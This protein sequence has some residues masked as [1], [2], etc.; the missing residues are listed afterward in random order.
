MSA[1]NNDSAKGLAESSLQASTRAVLRPSVVGDFQWSHA[2]IGQEPCTADAAQVCTFL[3]Q[4][5][6]IMA[7]KVEL[8]LTPAAGGRLSW[9]YTAV[10]MQGRG[11][12]PLPGM[13]SA[14]EVEKQIRDIF[15]RCK[16]SQEGTIS[17][18]IRLADILH[19]VKKSLSTILEAARADNSELP[20]LHKH[21][22][23]LPIY[24][25]FRPLSAAKGESRNLY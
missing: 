22:R 13:E 2:C 5:A 9:T 14:A 4:K 19:P 10:R 20:E 12:V 16:A 7:P 24:V 1:A 11:Y 6:G 25:D 17:T 15:K 21:S 3:D 23:S 8:Q 18:A